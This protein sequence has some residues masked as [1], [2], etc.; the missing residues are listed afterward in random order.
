M[1][2]NEAAA[3]SS[4]LVYS[5][6]EI[7]L[8]SGRATA[9]ADAADASLPGQAITVTDL[10]RAPRLPAPDHEHDVASVSFGLLRA[11]VRLSYF[12]FGCLLNEGH[13]VSLQEKT[14]LL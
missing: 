3:I 6:L 10:R 11:R 2:T 12:G 4:S 1:D 9:A 5:W 8:R 14:A 7:Y 13:G